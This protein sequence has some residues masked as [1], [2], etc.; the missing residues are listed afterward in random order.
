LKESDVMSS[1][2]QAG[3]GNLALIFLR[4]GVLATAGTLLGVL[5]HAA[6][7]FIAG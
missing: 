2:S 6:W 7:R 1:S 3:R 4:I 5:A